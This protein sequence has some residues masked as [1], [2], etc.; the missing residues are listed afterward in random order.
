VSVHFGCWERES[1]GKE[2]KIRDFF[3]KKKKAGRSLFFGF[4][5]CIFVGFKW[6]LGHVKFFSSFPS[7]L[8]DQTGIRALVHFKLVLTPYVLFTL[9]L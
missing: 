3:F 7:F 2:S 4:C 1:L 9:F 6:L 8:G 5:A